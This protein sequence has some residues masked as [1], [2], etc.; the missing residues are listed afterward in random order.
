MEAAFV[1]KRQEWIK[2]ASQEHKWLENDIN[3]EVFYNFTDPLSNRFYTLHLRHGTYSEFWSAYL[4]YDDDIN[5]EQSLTPL[6]H[7]CYEYEDLPHLKI[8]IIRCIEV[9]F[10]SVSGWNDEF[11]KPVTK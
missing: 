5:H 1:I 11:L 7:E 8:D 10:P 9:L 3:D 2:Y 6:L 4:S